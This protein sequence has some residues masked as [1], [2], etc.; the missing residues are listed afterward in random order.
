MLMPLLQPYRLPRTF[1]PP[2]LTLQRL[3]AHAIRQKRCGSCTVAPATPALTTVYPL[4]PFPPPLPAFKQ[5]RPT[6]AICQRCCGSC[7]GAPATA[8]PTSSTMVPSTSVHPHYRDH[9]TARRG[10]PNILSGQGQLGRG[11]CVQIKLL[12]STPLQAQDQLFR[13]GRP[14]LL[15]GQGQLRRGRCGHTA[16]LLSM[17]LLV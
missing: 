1:A 8:T 15:S 10:R 5:R 4:P 11:R 16:L 12:L 17:L 13:R 14:D 7:T 9:P 6:R 3:P 2:A